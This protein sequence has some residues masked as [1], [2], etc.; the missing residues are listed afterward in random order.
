MAELTRRDRLAV[1]A[2][3]DELAGEIDQI[4][5]WLDSI[6]DDCDKASVVLECG[7]RDLRAAAWIVKPA[8]HER[9]DGWLRGYRS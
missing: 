7:S 2:R 5:R 1:T 6:G 4:A 3:L 9:P 8:D